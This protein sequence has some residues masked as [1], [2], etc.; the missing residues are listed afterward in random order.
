MR[1]PFQPHRA[2]LLQREGCTAHCSLVA[3]R[4]VP[5]RA[6]AQMGSQLHELGSCAALAL[7]LDFK[8]SST[9]EE[10]K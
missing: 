6:C 9:K 7:S 3:L 5:S 2:L 8:E 4:D 10:K 1:A